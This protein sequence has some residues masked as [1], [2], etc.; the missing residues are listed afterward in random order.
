MGTN[1]EPFR[2]YLQKVC[3]HFSL[4]PLQEFQRNWSQNFQKNIKNMPKELIFQNFA[5]ISILCIKTEPNLKMTSTSSQPKLYKSY[6][7]QP[8]SDLTQPKID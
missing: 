1:L 2:A 3:S 4:I 5:C 6:V 7:T 8:E